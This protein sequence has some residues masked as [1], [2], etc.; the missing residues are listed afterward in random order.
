VVIT[1]LAGSV[2]P[3]EGDEILA[4]EYQTR[5]GSRLRAIRQQQG[6]TLQQVEEVSKGRW[7]A[8]VVGSYERGDRAVSVAKLAELGEFYGVPVTE[9]L[10]KE[11][12][13]VRPGGMP[14][15]VRLNLKRLSEGDLA[16]DLKPVA[17]FAH[18]IQ[19]QRGDFNGSV[20]TIRGEDL[21]ALSVI[22]GTEPEDLLRRLED[23]GALADSPTT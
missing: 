15:K 4:T 7:K 20:L 19:L 13:P 12:V 21:R 3:S 9:L 10:P 17:R 16:G 8:V 18:T 11:D 6:L 23:A 2:R 1:L 5:L 22:F 14:S